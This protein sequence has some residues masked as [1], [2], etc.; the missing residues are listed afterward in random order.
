MFLS[1]SAAENL[2]NSTFE[3]AAVI[4]ALKAIFAQTT[5][6]SCF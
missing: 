1:F 3:A 5:Q 4:M 2:K 6:N